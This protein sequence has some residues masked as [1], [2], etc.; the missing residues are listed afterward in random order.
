MKKV[1][2]YLLLA[3]NMNQP[4]F[5]QQTFERLLSNPNDET[6]QDI[7]EEENG[8]FLLAGRNIINES[9]II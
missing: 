3:L 4:A 6:I 8:N 1:I 9:S 7:I 2:F 5:S